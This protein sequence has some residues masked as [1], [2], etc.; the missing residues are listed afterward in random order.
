MFA[1]YG[2]DGFITPTFVELAWN[3]LA[4]EPYGNGVETHS[5]LVMG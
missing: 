5:I 1:N 2:G 4:I 3:F